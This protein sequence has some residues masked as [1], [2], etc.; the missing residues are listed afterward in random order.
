MPKK[1][2]IIDDE[3][4]MRVYLETMF[5]KAGYETRTAVNGQDALEQIRDYAP[6]LITLDILMPQKSGLSCFEALREHKTTGTVPIMIVSGVTGH[7][8]FFDQ[9]A[10]GGPTVFLEKPIKPDVVLSRSKELLG[11]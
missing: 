6:D 7:S 8:E 5:R 11:E 4:D 10:L 9:T 1:I 3:E 2:L